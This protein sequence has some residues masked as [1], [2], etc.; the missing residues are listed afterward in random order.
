MLGVMTHIFNPTTQEA[1]AGGCCERQASQDYM[2]R[3]CLNNKS[4]V[5]V[6]INLCVCVCATV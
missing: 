6:I 4:P 1:E 3:F 2:A 5:H